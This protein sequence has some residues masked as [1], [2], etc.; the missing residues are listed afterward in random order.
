MGLEH[1]V[2]ISWGRGD[3]C[4]G[5]DRSSCQA[6]PCDTPA[7]MS[8]ARTSLPAA[9]P[10]PDV[11]WERRPQVVAL[12]R[13]V[14]RLQQVTASTVVESIVAIGDAI[15]EIREEL[16]HGQWE[17]WRKEAVPFAAQTIANYM[18]LARWAEARPA[19]VEKL[20]HLGPSKL[21]LLLPL[22]S[23]VRRKLTSKRAHVL[24][25]GAKKTIDVMTVAELGQ[26]IAAGPRALAASEPARP[27][28][29]VV[30]RIRHRIAGLDAMT[31][32]LTQ[33][34]AEVEPEV[35]QELHTSL[36]ELADAVGE[37]FGLE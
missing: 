31:E 21:Y 16:P 17:R 4:V 18:A 23:A 22:E 2:A 28:R 15:L 12:T 20:A 6:A 30:R 8:R 7:P 10:G 9:Q 32:A 11:P 36:L 25:G 26:V 3:A 29:E 24:P 13:Q 5:S 33:R 37:A 27:I 1:V 14:L 34:H 19:E 35:A